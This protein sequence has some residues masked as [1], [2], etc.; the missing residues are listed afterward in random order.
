MQ[1]SRS[2]NKTYEMSDSKLVRENS[3]GKSTKKVISK[4]ELSDSMFSNPDEAISFRQPVAT[5]SQS[6]EVDKFL[7]HAGELQQLSEMDANL[8]RH[9]AQGGILHLAS[10]GS[11]QDLEDS[12][13][14][15]D[16]SLIESASVN[17]PQLKLKAI[18]RPV[19]DIQLTPPLLSLLSPTNPLPSWDP[20]TL[21]MIPT[22]IFHI[23]LPDITDVHKINLVNEIIYAHDHI[24]RIRALRVI[25]QCVLLSKQQA[26]ITFDT[27][28]RVI[29]HLMADRE[30]LLSLAESCC[31]NF[32]I[33]SL[34][35]QHN[36]SDSGSK[37]SVPLS[38]LHLGN[39]WEVCSLQMTLYPSCYSEE[40]NCFILS[41]S[42]LLIVDKELDNCNKYNDKLFSFI[43]C[44]ILS[45]QLKVLSCVLKVVLDR[46]THHHT[47]LRLCSSIPTCHPKCSASQVWLL[48]SSLT[49]THKDRR[50]DPSVLEDIYKLIPNI[51]LEL[52]ESYLTDR[53]MDQHCDMYKL[54]SELH[55]LYLILKYSKE[56]DWTEEQYQSLRDSLHLLSQMF[57]KYSLNLDGIKIKECIR[58]LLTRVDKGHSL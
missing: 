44:Q 18:M 12:N 35:Q 8:Q 10:L 20:S 46:V 15:T 39:I 53:D 29:S 27:L 56:A 28:I 55:M 22:P 16:N 33:I 41:L 23:Y 4:T 30:W 36:E 9:I 7:E 24:R 42:L 38:N 32:S 45:C 2:N 5:G 50:R 34:L 48:I 52:L 58:H 13:T 47:L 57:R 17:L 54:H 6:S 3:S 25:K 21:D 43:S 51:V 11:N 14:S 19:T 26:F 49:S 40:E 1:Q 37:S 31:L